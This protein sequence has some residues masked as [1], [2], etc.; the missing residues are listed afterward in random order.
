MFSICCVIWK[1]LLLI[2]RAYIWVFVSVFVSVYVCVF[3]N[4]DW[5]SSEFSGK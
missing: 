4:F 3:N 5:E 2:L 1:L